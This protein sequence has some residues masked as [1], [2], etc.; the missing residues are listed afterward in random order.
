MKFIAGI[1]QLRKWYFRFE[2]RKRDNPARP[3]VIG[4]SAPVYRATH[5]F[6]SSGVF[7]WDSMREL[8]LFA[9]TIRVTLPG[10][11]GCGSIFRRQLLFLL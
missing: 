10:A 11:S 8:P 9:K 2:T 1:A 7:A 5:C 3:L 6:L 4:G